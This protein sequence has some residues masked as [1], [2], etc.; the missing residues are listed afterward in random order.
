V[1]NE[2]SCSRRSSLMFS[3]D[4]CYSAIVSLVP[5][6][7]SRRA[8]AL[9]QLCALRATRPADASC[10]DEPLSTIPPGVR[11]NKRALHE[12]GVVGCVAPEAQGLC[13]HNLG[14]TLRPTVASEDVFNR[15]RDVAMLSNPAD[16]AAVCR[17]HQRRP[18]FMN[19]T[20]CQSYAT[21]ER[22]VRVSY[23][24]ALAIFVAATEAGKGF[25][26]NAK[27][28]RFSK[29]ASKA[30]LLFNCGA[31]A[32]AYTS[33]CGALEAI[34]DVRNAEPSERN[35]KPLTSALSH[36][37]H[38]VFHRELPDISSKLPTHARW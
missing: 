31:P 1:I 35:L 5:K 34:H 27:A 24:V 37:A 20:W 23:R 17:C 21:V 12:V 13:L 10:S 19:T 28:K 29:A 3:A 2:C 18:E 15:L 14:A 16:A 6:F 22:R 7:R 32:I 25:N 36:A 33:M 30:P 38:S 26:K 9:D 11:G 4:V 8:Y